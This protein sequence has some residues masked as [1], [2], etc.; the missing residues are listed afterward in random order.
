MRLTRQV[1]TLPCSGHR[2]TGGM[3]F[4]GHALPLKPGRRQKTGSNCEGYQAR[5][6]GVH[7]CGKVCA[8]E[9]LKLNSELSSRSLLLATRSQRGLV[10][11]LGNT[12]NKQKWH[13]PNPTV[14]TELGAR[15]LNSEADQASY[16]S[17]RQLR[18]GKVGAWWQKEGFPARRRDLEEKKGTQEGKGEDPGWR[19]YP[20]SGGRSWRPESRVE[21]SARGCPG[22]LTSTL[23]NW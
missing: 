13:V 22:T 6:D 9:C 5:R 14:N 11:N 18:L 17:H 20:G 4:C 8:C 10:V 21:T 16:C 19:K 7:V 1:L 2:L 12:W 15:S 23:R 3:R